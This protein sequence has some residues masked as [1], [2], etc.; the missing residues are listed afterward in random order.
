MFLSAVFLVTRGS[1]KALVEEEHLPTGHDHT[2][3]HQGLSSNLQWWGRVSAS[4]VV[5][6]DAGGSEAPCSFLSF[7]P[8]FYSNSRYLFIAS[9]MLTRVLGTRAIKET[10]ILI[11]QLRIAPGFLWL[12][13][14]LSEQLRKELPKQQLLDCHSAQKAG[15]SFPQVE[16]PGNLGPSS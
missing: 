9:H 13:L 14:F 15:L 2:L 4:A 6:G 7:S 3:N 5:C 8:T 1:F 12:F 11:N 16:G 10:E